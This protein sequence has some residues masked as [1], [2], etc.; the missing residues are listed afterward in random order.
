MRIADV[1]KCLRMLMFALHL[2]LVSH[3]SGEGYGMVDRWRSLY[4]FVNK[5]C[6]LD[7][8]VDARMLREKHELG[9]RSKRRRLAM[10]MIAARLG[11]RTTPPPPPKR[12]ARNIWSLSGK[13]YK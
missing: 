11:R 7:L 10:T 1:Y 12:A 6:T 2:I 13:L 3:R 9:K 5:Y 4:L 8:Y